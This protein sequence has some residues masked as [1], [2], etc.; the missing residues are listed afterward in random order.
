MRGAAAKK[1]SSQKQQQQQTKNVVSW[2]LTNLDGDVEGGSL[3][4][5]I[6]GSSDQPLQ[7]APPPRIVDQLVKQVGR[8]TIS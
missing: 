5:P 1:D 4:E 8:N 7:D 2:R 6:S 3:K